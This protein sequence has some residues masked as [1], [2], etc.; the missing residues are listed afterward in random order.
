MNETDAVSLLSKA[1]ERDICVWLDG[2]W[3]VDALVGRQTRPHGDIDLFVRRGDAAAFMELL[4]GE[5]FRETPAHFTTGGHTEW[6]T[7]D[8]RVVDLHLFE[9]AGDGTGAGDG[10]VLFEG[11][12][13]PAAILEGR[14]TIGGFPVRCLTPE[15]QLIYHQ[16]Y[17]HDGNDVRDVMLL[18]E[19]FGLPVPDEYFNG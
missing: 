16:G 19:T 11:E 14:G 15:A 8:G 4:G 12:S 5:G 10:T 17:E 7:A 3:G 1:A 2:G 9:F 18:C 13:Y 6:R